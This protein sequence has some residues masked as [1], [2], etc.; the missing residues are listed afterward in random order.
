MKGYE[1]VGEY[2]NQ[3]TDE[4]LP[5]VDMS[6]E[7]LFTIADSDV[8]FG[9]KGDQQL[10]MEARGVDR[11]IGVDPDNVDQVRARGCRVFK[12][13]IVLI[14]MRHP[15]IGWFMA[16]FKGPAMGNGFDKGKAFVGQI[17]TLRPPSKSETLIAKR[18]ANMD[19]RKRPKTTHRRT[20]SRQVRQNWGYKTI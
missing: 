19:R 8:K 13:G 2:H 7:K 18:L 10:C 17:F 3:F 15:R 9:I 14:P 20:A 1:I 4:L 16:R 6:T 5:V 12:H 11:S